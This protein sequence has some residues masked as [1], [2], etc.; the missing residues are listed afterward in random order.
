[1]E[2]RVGTCA[3]GMAHPGARGGSED[4]CPG[5]DNEFGRDHGATMRASASSDLHD[6]KLRTVTFGGRATLPRSGSWVTACIPPCA[7]TST[8]VVRH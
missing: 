4:Q 7:S 1:L 2:F 5:T 3:Y 6:S 8:D